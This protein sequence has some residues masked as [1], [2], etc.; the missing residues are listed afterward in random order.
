M[1]QPA[2]AKIYFQHTNLRYF[3]FPNQTDNKESNEILAVSRSSN[4]QLWV[5]TNGGGIYLFDTQRNSYKQFSSHSKSGLSLQNNDINLCYQDKQGNLWI[6]YQRI[7]LYVVPGKMVKSIL[8]GS[9]KSTFH[10]IDVNRFLSVLFI[11]NS[12]ITSFFEDSKGRLWIEGWGSLYIAEMSP[13]AANA[14][15]A[16]EFMAK[17][18]ATRVYSDDRKDAVKYPISP[19]LSTIEISNG[20]YWLGTFDAG[21][22]ELTEVGNVKFSG[23]QLDINS[24]LPSCNIKCLYKR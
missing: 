2:L 7:G 15:S 20:K 18:K 22:I 10:P 14:T 8:N 16:E 4:S 6:V 21:I 9:T 3:N 13:D 1:N 23:R 11:T 17:S 24:K 12:Y 5:S 19:I